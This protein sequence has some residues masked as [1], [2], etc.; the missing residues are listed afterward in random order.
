LSWLIKT[1][2]DQQGTR[3]ALGGKNG[4]GPRNNIEGGWANQKTLNIP[5]PITKLWSWPKVG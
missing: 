4:A 5:E 1:G 2:K 3:R